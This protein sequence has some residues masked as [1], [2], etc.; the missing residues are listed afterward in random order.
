MV[1]PV[2]VSDTSPIQYLHQAGQLHLLP[3]LFGQV[4][5][6]PAVIA[7]IGIGIQ[8]G[9]DLPDLDRL[10][11]MVRRSPSVAPSFPGSADLDAGECEAIALALELRC[12]ILISAKR[13]GFVPAIAPLID[14][15][16]QRGY[17]LSDAI[18]MDAL[19]L[20]GEA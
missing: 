2:V 16:V 4:I 9:L 18:R 8:R 11:W 7:E 19:R 6:P 12:R 17:R 20:A 10:S 13:A 5:V 1:E 14:R 3:A 15:V